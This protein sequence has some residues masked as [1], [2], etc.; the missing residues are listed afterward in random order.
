MANSLAKKAY[1]SLT[2]IGYLINKSRIKI[3][4]RDK[5]IFCKRN[6]KVVLIIESLLHQSIVPKIFM[7]NALL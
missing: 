4:Y 7:I 5:K 2:F 6:Y 1:L 3:S